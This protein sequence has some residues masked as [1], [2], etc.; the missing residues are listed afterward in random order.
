MRRYWKP[1]ISAFLIV[2]GT[3]AMPA[4]TSEQ[5]AQPDTAQVISG[6]GC[7]EAGVE[8]GCL[9]LKDT[10]TKTLYNLF[11]SGRG[12]A[13]GAAI[14]FTGAANGGVNVCMQGKPVDVKKWAQLKMPCPVPGEGKKPAAAK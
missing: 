2:A 10:K 14:Q 9:V 5:P 1:K 12:P 3:L 7:V 8:A 4:Q 11:F 13:P 6:S